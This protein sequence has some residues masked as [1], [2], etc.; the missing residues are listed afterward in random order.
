MLV[1]G[2]AGEITGMILKLLSPPRIEVASFCQSV[3]SHSMLHLGFKI[4]LQHKYSTDN[5]FLSLRAQ[6]NLSV[7]NSK[8]HLLTEM[9]LS[10][11]RMRI[12]QGEM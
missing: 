6:G 11:T 9:A 1:L 12:C 8:I 7:Q 5:S 3:T 4:N 10:A 2:L